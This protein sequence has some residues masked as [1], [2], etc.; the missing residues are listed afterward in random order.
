VLIGTSEDVRTL[1]AA[2]LHSITSSTDIFVAVAP[3][4]LSV[5][6]AA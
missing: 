5:E 3:G 2:L 1:E 6:L 4:W